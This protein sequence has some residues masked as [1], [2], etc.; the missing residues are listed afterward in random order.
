[1]KATGKHHRQS[2]QIENQASRKGF[3]VALCVVV[4]LLTTGLFAYAAP[5]Q[6]VDVSWYT[7]NP[8]VSEYAID[9]PAQMRG[10]SALVNGTA[11]DDQDAPIPAVDFEGVTI[12]QDKDF[13]LSYLVTEFTPIG[14]EEHPF[15]GAFDGQGHSVSGLTITVQTSNAGLFGVTS[16]T[17]TLKN[18]TIENGQFDT[19]SITV[20]T[21]SAVVK[22]IGSLVGNCQGTIENCTS[23]AT[24]TVESD[25][26]AT[27][28]DPYVVRSVGGLAGYCRGDLKD[29]SFTGELTA[30][31]AADSHSSV[32]GYR[33]ADSFGG[34]VG[35]FGDPLDHGTIT[36]CYNTGDIWVYTTGA[37]DKDRFGVI[38]YARTF[39]VGGVCGY[40]NGS[41][42]NSHN[43]SYDELSRETT[44][45]VS[46]SA[47]DAIDGDP[48]G[49]RGAD[50]VG[51]IVGGFRSFSDD[52][53]KYNDGNPDDPLYVQ[54][55]Y[56]LGSLTGCVS[57]GGVVAEAGCYT[58]VT[59]CYNGIP[60]LEEVGTVVSTRWN[61]PISGGV[62][63]RTW[64]G[65]I[66]YCANYAQVEN[67][68]TGYY[69]A[70][71]AGAIW[72]SDDYPELVPELYSCMNTG[73]V[74][75]A[76]RTVGTEFREAGI[77]GANE[78]YVHDCIML[79]GTVLYHDDSPIGDNTWG[80][81]SNLLTMTM[82]ELQ[83]SE[84][85]AQLNMGAAANGW[86]VYWYVNGSGYPILNVWSELGE[87]VPLT[88]DEIQTTVVEEQAK[89]IS[90]TSEP[91]P[92]LSIEL[93]NG[94]TLVQGADFYV[95]P[96]AGAVE[97][98]GS[99]STP[100][101]ASVVGIGMYE[102]TVTDL[103][104][105]GILKGDFSKATVSVPSEKYN[106]GKAVFPE[107]VDVL[108]DGFKVDRDEYSYVIYDS[109]TIDV[110]DGKQHFVVYDSEGFVS[111]NNGATFVPVK[112]ATLEGSYILYD[113]TMVKISDSDG[114]VF[115]ITGSNAGKPIGNRTSCIGY[116]GTIPAGYVLEA[117]AYADSEKLSGSVTGQYIVGALDLNTDCTVDKVAYEDQ[118]WYWDS[119]E[120][121]LYILDGQGGRLDGNPTVVFTGEQISPLPTLSYK[122]R[123]LTVDEDYKNVYGDPYA[124]SSDYQANRNVT[125]E[126]DGAAIT[127]NSANNQKFRN[128]II[129][130]FDIIPA[131]FSDC[132]VSLASTEYA[133]TGSAVEPEVTVELDGVVLE[134]DVDYEVTYSNNTA[135][136]SAATYEVTPLTNL[137]DG[138]T[139]PHTGTFKIIDG[140][141]ISGYTIDTIPDQYYN[142]GYDVNAPIVIRNG[143]SVVN[144]VKGVDYTVTYSSTSVGTCTVTVKGIGR[145]TGTL[146]KD[147]QIVAFDAATNPNDQLVVTTQE[148][149]YGTWGEEKSGKGIGTSAPVMNVTAY[150]IKNWSTL[151]RANG[152]VI[153]ST[154]N[155]T[156]GRITSCVYYDASGKEVTYAT[157]TT[158]TITA[159]ITFGTSVG[160]NEKVGGA[161]G[162]MRT[163][164]LPYGASTDIAEGVV[165]SSSVQTYDG[166]VKTPI[167]GTTTGQSFTLKEGVDYTI[168]YADN[169]EAGSASY[170]VTAKSGSHYT[171]TYQGQFSIM[172]ASLSTLGATVAF[173]DQQLYTG[174]FVK[175][176][177]TIVV[178]DRTLVEN[179][180]Y[181]LSYSN[182]VN[183]G[184][185]TVYISGDGN[186]TGR[187][188]ATFEIRD[189]LLPSLSNAVISNIA[190]QASTGSAVTPDLTVTLEGK[191][192]VKDE[193]YTVTYSNNV[194]AGTAAVTI[195]GI[196]DYRGRVV[197]TFTIVDKKAVEISGATYEFTPDRYGTAA[198]VART[199]YPDGAE[200]VI[201][202]YGL[203]FPD[204]L[205]ASSLAGMLDYPILL[206]NQNELAP[207]TAAVIGQLGAKKVIIVGGDAAVSNGVKDSLGQ[208]VGA[209]NVAR[210]SGA[211]R[212]ETQQAIYEYGKAEGTWSDTAIIATGR[213]F[214]DALAVAPYAAQTK[215]SIFLVGDSLNDTA[216]SALLEDFRGKKVVIVGGTGVVSAG[217]EQWIKDNLGITPERLGGATRYETSADI[218]AFCVSDGFSYDKVAITTGRNFADALAGGILQ[219][220]SNSVVIL[221]DTSG[222][223]SNSAIESVAAHSA[224]IDEIRFLGGTGVITDAHRAAIIQAFGGGYRS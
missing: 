194:N 182:N 77:L 143:S 16:P 204:S 180:D 163:A 19:S 152:V 63:G 120:A 42:Y 28:Q 67:I 145:C 198:S 86:E 172:A 12:K 79:K 95:V 46:T 132:T 54:N 71:I 78:G 56:N 15:A 161:T 110:N 159:A 186:Y 119:E 208:I 45:T 162:T 130:Y 165:W 6:G 155:A 189:T 185:A 4:A 100:Y 1:M 153:T 147:F 116:K 126:A 97:I 47:I 92:V 81:Y 105:Y 129:M 201:V 108:I 94:K 88:A 18:I 193:D 36:A 101:K 106:F 205:A 13:V 203:N 53:A 128:Y 72:K 175:P 107:E 102:G 58:T 20:Q 14:T 73:H 197:K 176:A 149:S 65:T 49:N 222:D 190:R 115:Y 157:A 17:S 136:T 64:G 216:K 26:V 30:R 22:N 177:V 61:K 2:D 173:E 213:N 31:I 11:V 148:L 109:A 140:T 48:L 121:Q 122:G 188:N 195:K 75:T 209:S 91:V 223:G 134:E 41:I 40:S 142:F 33:V 183:V 214:A 93:K 7:D 50:Q 52:P 158:G 221:A 212:Y 99:G 123:Q 127:V 25:T 199:A 32:E 146:T 217:V 220:K 200:G 154:N 168:V 27:E 169:V 23:S 84:A 178:G 111:F 85:A 150:P 181:W 96:E 164:A 66:S 114:Q 138:D 21:S 156:A 112:E 5:I 118:T 90:P 43:G 125:T 170:T 133:Y 57:I 215:S 137:S 59:Q 69:M 38:T 202:A 171:G 187:I 151:E 3:V 10:L 135:K 104:E 166:T 29:S 51:G 62:L 179:T 191:K 224:D 206:T 76:N 80:M 218:A 160:S 44:G 124:E 196:G 37:G 192:L 167:T 98:T 60:S 35:R 68:Q 34:V 9:S 83:T 184:T 144:L 211:D 74:Y 70:G 8:G 210:L 24:I 39:F 82:E 113:R 141:S 55:C 89:Y 207:S 139:T 87:T 103:V 117:T 131:K 219:A 174:D